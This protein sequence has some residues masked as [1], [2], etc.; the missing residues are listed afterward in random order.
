MLIEFNSSFT[1]P[2]TTP[3]PLGNKYRAST[4]SG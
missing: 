1:D 2:E 4:H 3:F